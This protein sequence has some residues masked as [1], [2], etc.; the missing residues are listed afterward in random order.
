MRHNSL[1][2]HQAQAFSLLTYSQF[3]EYFL[4]PYCVCRLIEHN[5]RVHFDIVYNILKD[6]RNFVSVVHEQDDEGK[7]N[8]VD[9]VIWKMG[10]IKVI[11]DHLFPLLLISF[12]L[13]EYRTVCLLVLIVTYC[14][15]FSSLCSGCPPRLYV[16]S[17]LLLSTE[18]LLAS[19][20]KHCAR[21][22]PRPIPQP[23]SAAIKNAIPLDSF[24]TS[25]CT[26]SRTQGKAKG[27]SKQKWTC[28]I[29]W[30][31][32]SRSGFCSADHTFCRLAAIQTVSS[33]HHIVIRFVLA[34]LQCICIHWMSL[35]CELSDKWLIHWV[36]VNKPLKLGDSDVVFGCFFT[37]NSVMW[38][39]KPR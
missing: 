14:W 29:D 12:S 8:K 3:L 35:I 36:W 18:F 10:T 27:S 39:L 4:I 7:D 31:H 37:W 15:K 2:N 16:I 23:S 9:D 34:P 32:T 21:P 30:D 33:L 38:S 19:S 6:S 20:L 5:Q 28:C 17:E 25:H 13:H 1:S 22:V 11:S 26:H 24:P